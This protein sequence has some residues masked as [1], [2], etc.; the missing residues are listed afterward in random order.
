MKCAILGKSIKNKIFFI[1]FYFQLEVSE[2]LHTSHLN[3]DECTGWKRLES[4]SCAT[5]RQVLSGNSG[6]IVQPV[7]YST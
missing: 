1:F 6:E 5:I 7:N 3:D 2:K 4:S